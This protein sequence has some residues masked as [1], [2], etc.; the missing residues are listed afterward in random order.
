MAKDTPSW[1][2][3]HPGTFSNNS[4]QKADRSVKQAMS[5][6]E[7]IAVEHAF[8][9][10]T[11]AEKA[12]ANAAQHDEHMD[13]VRQNKEQLNLMK[14]QLSEVQEIVEDQP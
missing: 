6:P 11:R 8:N 2:K 7:E 4:V 9:S 14:Q 3:V 10:I 5:H 13:T 1:K 12:V